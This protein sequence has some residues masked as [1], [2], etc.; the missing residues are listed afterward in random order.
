LIDHLPQVA[1]MRSVRYRM[2][3]A[4]FAANRRLAESSFEVSPFDR[5]L[6]LDYLPYGQARL[7]DDR[8]L[9]PRRSE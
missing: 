2:R 6:V 4:I 8:Y 1:S 3:A 9:E 7:A 5:A